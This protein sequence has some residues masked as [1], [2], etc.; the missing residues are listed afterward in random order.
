MIII[1]RKYLNN[2]IDFIVQKFKLIIVL[3]LAIRYMRSLRVN[4]FSNCLTCCTGVFLDIR[5][6]S[7]VYFISQT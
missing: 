6:P 3:L 7:A 5:S 1:H 2:S 4:Y